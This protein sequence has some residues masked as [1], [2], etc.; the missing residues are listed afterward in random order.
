[1]SEMINVIDWERIRH[2]EPSEYTHPDR[3]DSM[4]VQMMDAMRH[5]EDLYR[6]K[7]GKNG[8][9]ITLDE[10][11]ALRPKNPKSQ[12]PKGK[13]QD[14]VIRDAVTREPLDVFEQFL[15]ASRYFWTGIGFYPFWNNPGIHVDTRT[16]SIYQRRATWWRDKDGKYLNVEQYLSQR[17]IL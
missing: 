16:L 7:A 1:M 5:E 14:A 8:I 3:M 11:Y 10:T 6:R 17:M 15:I 2:F 13:A 12:H 4:A 9:I